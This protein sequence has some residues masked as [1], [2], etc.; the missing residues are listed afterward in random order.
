MLAAD[1]KTLQS[2]ERIKNLAE[3]NSVIISEAAMPY[4]L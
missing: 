1:G 2:P 4:G 3:V